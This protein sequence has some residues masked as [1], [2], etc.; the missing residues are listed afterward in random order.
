MSHLKGQLFLCSH[1]H[2]QVRMLILVVSVFAS[3]PICKMGTV[4]ITIS[5][6][7]CED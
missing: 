5:E 4:I 3:A 1:D 6:S 2:C 7:W